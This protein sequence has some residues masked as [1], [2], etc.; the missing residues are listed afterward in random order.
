MG[1]YKF[2]HLIHA[3][4]SMKPRDTIVI[5]DAHLDGNE[6]ELRRFLSQ[7][8]S[9]CVQPIASL[10]L[11]GDIFDFWVGTSKMTLPHHAAVLKALIA[12][13]EQGIRLT[14][15]EGNRDYF[16]ARQ[17]LHAPFHAV[18]SEGMQLEIAGRQ[19]YFSHGDLINRHD[20]KYRSWR[21]F[22]RNSCL[23][24]AFSVM[25]QPIMIRLAQIIE[26]RLRVTNQRYKSTFPTAACHEYAEM[27]WRQGVDVVALG[28]FHQER[29]LERRIGDRAK[30]LLVLPA[31]KDS[32]RFLR[33][34]FQGDI[35]LESSE[36]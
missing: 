29:H 5:A 9:C 27:H 20:W 18:T 1:A 17:F 32:H 14:Y 25:P 19:W 10:I 6:T 7:L 8:E 36:A 2:P 23:F 30:E 26:K 16:L 15:I 4:H 12:A 31:W 21:R 13:K 24:A 33:I 3:R 28:H 22:S 34:S 35:S 11:L